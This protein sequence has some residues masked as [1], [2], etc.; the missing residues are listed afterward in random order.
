M[1]DVIGVGLLAFGA[2]CWLV[3][4]VALL[5]IVERQGR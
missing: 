2:G 1:L 4:L 3:A 5:W